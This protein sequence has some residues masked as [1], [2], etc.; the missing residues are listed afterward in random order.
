MCATSGVSWAFLIFVLFWFFQDITVQAVVAGAFSRAAAAE[1][2]PAADL[3]C[4]RDYSKNCPTGWAFDGASCTAPENYA[5][6]CS[7]KM[8]FEN[9]TPLE[10]STLAA[11][12]GATFPCLGSC[13]EDY[14]AACPLGWSVDVDGS[15]TAPDS[16]EGP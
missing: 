16:Y 9:L 4:S 7:P 14:D 3:V 1:G 2:L 6:E 11:K 8:Q 12:C 10:K 13:V 5:G 15:C